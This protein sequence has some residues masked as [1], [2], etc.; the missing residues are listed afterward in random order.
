MRTITTC[1]TCEERATRAEF[2]PPLSHV[3]WGVGP[4]WM[5]YCSGGDVAE[6]NMWCLTHITWH[7]L[8]YEKVVC[9]SALHGCRV[10]SVLYWE[11]WRLSWD[12]F[13]ALSSEVEFYFVWDDFF[14][15]NFSP[16]FNLSGFRSRVKEPVWDVF[17]CSLLLCVGWCVTVVLIDNDG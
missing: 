16:T 5:D 2:P 12:F 1:Q 3:S 10:D 9:C 15:L 11:D 13:S 17:L 14:F 7:N 8:W 4:A 6:S